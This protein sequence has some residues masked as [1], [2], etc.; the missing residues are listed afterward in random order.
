MYLSDQPKA[1]DTLRLSQQERQDIALQLQAKQPGYTKS[2]RRGNRRLPWDLRREASLSVQN[3]GG[4]ASSFVVR[5]CEISKSGASLLH[6]GF[7]YPNSKCVLTLQDLIKQKV[8]VSGRIV[9]CQLLRGHVHRV[10]VHFDHPLDLTRFLEAAE[11]EEESAEQQIR[12]R[13]RTELERLLNSLET[14]PKLQVIHQQ[15][16]KLAE[17]VAGV[18]V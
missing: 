6:G 16:T 5:P 9:R 18:A 8:D 10:A 13:L 3:P 2:N 4:T 11:N 17:D 14:E 1:V 7:I 15:L 12:E